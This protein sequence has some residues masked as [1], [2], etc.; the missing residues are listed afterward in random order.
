[1]KLPNNRGQTLHLNF[2]D[3][4][5]LSLE[6]SKLLDSGEIIKV[7]T[8]ETLTEFLTTY[9]DVLTEEDMKDFCAEFD[10]MGSGEFSATELVYQLMEDLIM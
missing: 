5:A 7:V 10:G 2:A 8:K 9:G 6:T 3:N 1:M 4:L